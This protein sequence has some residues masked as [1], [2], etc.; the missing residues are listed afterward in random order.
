MK[1]T[2]TYA[3]TNKVNP[4]VATLQVKPR[5]YWRVIFAAGTRV[6][7]RHEGSVMLRPDQVKRYAASLNCSLMRHLPLNL[8]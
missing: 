7:I 8:R 3:S 2:R 4:P 6:A 5:Q 1:P